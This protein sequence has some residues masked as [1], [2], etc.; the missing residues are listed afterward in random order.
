VHAAGLDLHREEHIQALEEHGV[1]V[2]E[3]ARQDPG[4]LRD[5]GLPPG[6]GCPAWRGREPGCGEDPADGSCADAMPEAEELTLDAA[7]SP[8]RV[9]PGQPPDQLADLLRDRR[10]SGGIR[11]G[12]LLLDHAPVPGKQCGGCHDPVQPQVPGEQPGERGDHGPVGPVR[13]RAGDLAAQDCDLM[14][15]Y[16]D[17]DVLGGFAAAEQHHPAEQPDHEQVEEANEHDRRG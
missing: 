15:Q 1:N 17:L 11:I 14:P 2:H 7:V 5:Q 9:L 16:Q 13:F 8:P 12:P 6:R 4:C 3:V 10:A